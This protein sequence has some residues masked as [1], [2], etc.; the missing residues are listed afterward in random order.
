[1]EKISKSVHA[2]CTHSFCFR[3]F[4]GKKRPTTT[5][6]AITRIVSIAHLKVPAAA[7]AA[8]DRVQKLSGR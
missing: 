1:M 2:S 3:Y 5:P 4:A 7:P 8:A 6:A